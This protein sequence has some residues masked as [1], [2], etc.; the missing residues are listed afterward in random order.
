V[1]EVD[2]RL[3]IAGIYN[4]AAICVAFIAKP[5]LRCGCG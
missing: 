5:R 2:C 3:Q 1:F 4:L